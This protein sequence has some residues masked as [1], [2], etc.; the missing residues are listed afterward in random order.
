MKK[1]LRLLLMGLFVLFAGQTFAE[2]VTI[3]FDDDYATLFPTITGVSS[4]DSNEGDFT[5][6]TTSEAVQ[7]VTVT[8]TPAEDAKTPS[9]IWSGSPRLRM[10]SGTFTV[11][12]T[13]ITKIVINAPSKFNMTANTGTLDGKTWTGDKTSEVVFNVGGNTQIKSIVV[14]L[15]E[16]GD[17]P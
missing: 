7:G 15:G 10:Y 9:R 8:V 17:T 5:G 14:T 12:G 4:N 3:N 6:P 16:G 11:N 1:N 2:E 13:D